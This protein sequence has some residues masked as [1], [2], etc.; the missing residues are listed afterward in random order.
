M[1]PAPPDYLLLLDPEST[2]G[3]HPEIHDLPLG[4]YHI[5]TRTLL[6]QKQIYI[7]PSLHPNPNP[8][9]DIVRPSS[10]VL[11]A[12]SLPAALS[13]ISTF[14]THSF[15]APLT[16][17]LATDNTP[18]LSTLTEEAA[19]KAVTLPPE[20]ST[21]IDLAAYFRRAMPSRADT[22]DARLAALGIVPPPKR[23]GLDEV[24]L[25]SLLAT[26]LLQRAPLPAVTV[27]PAAGA[28]ACATPVA[29]G[30]LVG[31][32]VRLRGLP[33]AVSSGDVAGFLRGVDV[34]PG[35]VHFVR[36]R[37]GKR[38]GE[39]FVQVGSADGVGEALRR[40][41]GRLGR[42][43]VEVFSCGAGEVIGRRGRFLV[44]VVG[45]PEET[46]E[47]ELKAGFEGAEGGWLVRDGGGWCGEGVVEFREEG[48][49]RRAVGDGRRVI[50]VG[51]KEVGVEV[52]EDEE[53]VVRMRGLPYSCSEGDIRRF[54]E[55]FANGIEADGI[56][57]GKDGQGRMS[58]EAYVKFMTV[59]DARQVVKTLD[60]RHIGSRYIELNF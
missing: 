5:P 42:R 50:W 6:D 32:M 37:Y 30:V 41:R 10:S 33:W 14:L 55:E 44:R 21:H 40:H 12:R 27:G 38:V 49:K 9:S 18:A 34:V 22:R 43:Y 4:I 3:L 26:A 57:R 48:S 29:T 7:T 15:P 51:G 58:G 25:L 60:K 28:A 11:F 24:A 39:A 13:H 54:F 56:F 1:S 8:P 31:G 35:G 2:F 20:F 59:R 19:R 52:V 47:A 45:L 23:S 53:R 16:V 36:N 17:A 46:A